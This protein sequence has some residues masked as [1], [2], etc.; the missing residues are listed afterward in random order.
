ML[1]SQNKTIFVGNMS[2]STT[3]D[4]LRDLFASYGEVLV[5]HL[6]RHR[7]SGESR[8]FGFVKMPRLEAE[9]AIEALDGKVLDGRMIRVSEAQP[10]HARE[11][12]FGNKGMG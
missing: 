8:G 6:V 7:E 10:R 11:S 3:E 9:V 4:G 2:F 5:V 12:G 1:G